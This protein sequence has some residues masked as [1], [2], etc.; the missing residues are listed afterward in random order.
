KD[1]TRTQR[2]P[3]PLVRPDAR[4]PTAI[5]RSTIPFRGSTR[6]RLRPNSLPTHTL[7]AAAAIACGPSPTGIVAR[8]ESRAGSIR[9]TVPSRLFA[10]HTAPVLN[11]TPV[12]PQQTLLE[13]L[14]VPL[15]H[16]H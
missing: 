7:P 16:N 13:T 12:G 8:T 15:R 4:P 11:A 5:V 1:R 10:I 9:A 6:D 2:G 14:T 3:S